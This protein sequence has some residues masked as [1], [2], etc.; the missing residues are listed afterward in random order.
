[1]TFRD[2]P[3]MVMLVLIPSVVWP[4]SKPF[5]MRRSKLISVR[6]PPNYKDSDELAEWLRASID[7]DT[8]GLT[9]QNVK[10]CN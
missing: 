9:L 6:E 5:H 3:L 10:I 1:M 7:A 4:A 8:A 2:S